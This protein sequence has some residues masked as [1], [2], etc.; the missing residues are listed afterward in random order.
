M[1]DLTDRMR[2][3]AAYIMSRPNDAPVPT[4][5]LLEDAADLLIAAS[6]ALET[7]PADL[8]EPMALLPAPPPRVAT[9]PTLPSAP[10]ACPNCGAHTANIV[11][12]VGAQLLLTCASCNT[13]FVFKPQATWT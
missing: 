7:M 12:R 11:R 8:G 6:N 13:Q 3:C 2:T 5:H 1:S 9:P 4:E 10:R